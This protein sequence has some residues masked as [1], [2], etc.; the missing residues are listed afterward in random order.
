MKR[1]TG[2]RFF[3]VNLLLTVF[4]IPASLPGQAAEKEN[5]QRVLN[6]FAEW[7]NT[8]NSIP[9]EERPLLSEHGAFGSSILVRSQGAATS[10]SSQGTFVFA[11][12]LD[13][14]FAVDT[15]LAV[16]DRLFR[17]DASVNILIAF[18]G[19]ERNE[20]PE[21]LGPS[22]VH[23]RTSH[24][25]LHDLMS[26]IDMPENWVLCYLDAD[27]AP[28]ELVLRHGI[29][30][31]VA[32]LDIIQPLPYL[33]GIKGIPWSFAIRNNSI[34]KLGLVEGPEPLSIAWGEE[35]NGF[36]LSGA[37]KHG[38]TT[39]T[40][41]PETL[42]ELLLEYPNYLDLPVMNPDRHYSFFTLPNGNFYFAAEGFSVTLLFIVIGI[43]LFLYLLYS[44]RYN[45][46]LVYHIRL[47]FKFFWVFLLLLPWLVVSLKASALIYSMLFRVLS[48]PYGI[49]NYA[50]VGLTFMLAVLVFF[51]PSPALDLLQF[52]RRARF[53]GFSA[54]IFGIIGIL[55][56]AFLD[57]SYVPVFLWAFVFIFLGAIFSRPIPV[58]LSALLVPFLVIVALLNIFE[59]GSGR[60]LDLFVFSKLN[61]PEGWTV[62]IQIA[63]LTL[64]ILLLMGRGII[65]FKKHMH[66]KPGQRPEKSFGLINS[67]VA[68]LTIAATG[69]ILAMIG[70]IIFLKLN[71]PPM[72]RYITTVLEINNGDGI[73]NLSIDDTVFQDSR[74]IT[75][76]LEADGNPVRFDVSLETL[77]DKSLF[78][79]YSSSVPFERGGDGNRI[80]FY[81][82]EYPSNPLTMEIVVPLE[83]EGSLEV[84]AIYNKWDPAVFPCDEQDAGE[85]IL[86][87]SKSTAFE[88][89][90]GIQR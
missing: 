79:V 70:Q 88:A 52:R 40:I 17:G 29:Q 50:G 16:T 62:S 5:F 43:L 67:Y 7:E 48:A 30:G 87:V 53:Y 90:N 4:L 32:P 44:I 73:V 81:M 60:L 84:T 55:I 72:Q 23:V 76:N 22:H 27:E 69:L 47:F 83:F 2:I 6:G 42:A 80:E 64:P 25:G 71:P 28:D 3:I 68:F 8:G 89:T 34:Y 36:V 82:G 58:F 33:F 57:F 15:A 35:V 26:L 54:V 51:L 13:A 37:E 14:D 41:S 18:L 39:E 9:F 12:P 24:M 20:L 66:R 19:S 74:I 78:P 61:A 21:D 38:K 46:V 1:R 11:V 85:H 63:L 49:V 77:T 86:L 59:T 56:S 65:L 75:L 10:P 31:Y 45:A